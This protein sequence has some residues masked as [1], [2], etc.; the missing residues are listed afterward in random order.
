MHRPLALMLLLAA[1][2]AAA[3]RPNILFIFSDDHAYQAVSAYGHGLNQTPNLDRLAKEGML[4]R[5]CF[6]TNSLCG[7]SRAVVQTGKYSHLNGYYGNEGSEVFNGDQQTFPKLLQKAGYQTAIV[8]KWHLI[9]DPQGFDYWHILY[10]QGQYYNP[11]MKENGQRVAHTGYVTD[12]TAD[13]TLDWLQNKRDPNKPFMLMYQNKAPHRDWEPPIKMLHMFDGQTIPEPET[14]FDNYDGRG[15]AAHQQDMTIAKTMRMK[16]DL[17]VDWAPPQLSPEQKKQW[18]EA[19]GPENEAMKKANL[20]GDDLT[21]W[22]Y[23]RYMKDYLRCVA[24]VDENVGR[25]LDYLD[26][27]GLA[28]NT[29]VIYTSDQGFYLGEHGWFDKRWIYEESLRTPLMVRWPGVTDAG[30][31]SS[32]IVSNLDFAETM[33]DAAGVQVPDD[34]QGRSFV[35]ILK[36]HTPDDWRKSFYY[37]YYEYEPGSHHVQPHYGVRTEN[38]MLVH[39]PITGEYELYDMIKDRQQMHSVYDDPAYAKEAAQLKDEIKRLQVLYK[40]TEPDITYK[41]IIERIKAARRKEHAQAPRDVKFQQVLHVAKEGDATPASPDPSGKPLTVG[42]WCTPTSPDGVLIA[43]GGGSLGFS[44]YLAKGVPTFAVRNEDTLY[45]VAAPSAVK[46]SEPVHLAGAI[47]TASKLHLY[48]NGKE[49]ASADGSVISDQPHE[50]LSIGADPGSPVG[51]YDGPEKFNG[52]YH[53]LRLYWG[54]IDAEKLASWADQ[55]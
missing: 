36:G 47:D 18:D 46:M 29:I 38:Y 20:S 42:G 16:Q 52:E 8:G 14:L 4:F 30:S 6:V 31:T 50:G 43:Q 45:K 19:Y 1:A 22:K 5:N 54:A 48:V 41:Q 53:D 3:D 44:L 28:K 55:P 15:T 37:H 26:K 40:D 11:P 49:V 9:S 13:I 39:F 23:Q 24:S 17:K 35:P 2:V 10:G 32:A 12:I 25:V 7:P 27:S 51:E 21:R 34:M 33:L